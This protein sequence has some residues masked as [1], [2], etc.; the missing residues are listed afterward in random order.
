MLHT[1]IHTYIH[2]Y[3]HT[4][5]HTHTPAQTLMKPA[6]HVVIEGSFTVPLLYRLVAPFA[7]AFA[8][9]DVS[10]RANFTRIGD[11]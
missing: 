11:E 10:V 4:H 1:Y 7:P 9:H 2:A 6:V 5:P 3:I 8:V